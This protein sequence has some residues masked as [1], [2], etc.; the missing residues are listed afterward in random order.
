MKI[1]N[2]IARIL[3]FLALIIISPIIGIAIMVDVLNDK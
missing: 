2:F 3:L 1:I